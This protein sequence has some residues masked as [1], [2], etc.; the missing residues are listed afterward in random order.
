LVTNTI[1]VPASPVKKDPGSYVTLDTKT[2]PAAIMDS[3]VWNAVTGTTRAPIVTISKRNIPDRAIGKQFDGTFPAPGSTGL[4][5]TFKSRLA[6]NI[7]DFGF[8]NMDFLSF[9]V[10]IF[11]TFS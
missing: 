11:T 6:G 7:M 2:L 4:F 9:I 8:L 1:T 10:K 3:G 5:F